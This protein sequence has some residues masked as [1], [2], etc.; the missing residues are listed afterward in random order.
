M[1]CGHLIISANSL[2][3]KRNQELLLPYDAQFQ[4]SSRHS[5]DTL[6]ARLLLSLL[7]LE[8]CRLEQ[9]VCT[10]SNSTSYRNHLLLF[11]KHLAMNAL[12]WK[13][14]TKLRNS[15]YATYN[16][17]DESPSQDREII[18]RRLG[19]HGVGY[20]LR[21]GL[22]CSKSQCYVLLVFAINSSLF[23][24]SYFR[25]ISIFH[26]IFIVNTYRVHTSMS[27]KASATNFLINNTINMSKYSSIFLQ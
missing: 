15:I 14:R 4:L 24:K 7:A 25:N 5:G 21:T 26:F 13:C 2:L 22:H 10:F 19:T 6:V 8:L 3:Q 12:N 23:V 9:N 16:L 1:F 17:S 18:Q 11:A 20:G 27:Q